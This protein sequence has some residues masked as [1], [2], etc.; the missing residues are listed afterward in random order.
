MEPADG[1]EQRL[2]EQDEYALERD[3]Q[4]A[5]EIERADEF[6]DEIRAEVAS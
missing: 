1:P 3:L 4:D 2:F 6:N 5:I